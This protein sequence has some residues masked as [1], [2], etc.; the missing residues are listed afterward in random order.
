LTG[1]TRQ[2][3]HR[4]PLRNLEALS[5]ERDKEPEATVRR[6]S[7]KVFDSKDETD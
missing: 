1:K 3:K 5:K 7:Q 6:K 2:T 4:D